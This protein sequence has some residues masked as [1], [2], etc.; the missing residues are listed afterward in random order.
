MGV[1]RD[2]EMKQSWQC[3]ISICKSLRRVS[4][5]G[6]AHNEQQLTFVS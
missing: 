3:G 2:R 4:K 1:V 5:T 6:E